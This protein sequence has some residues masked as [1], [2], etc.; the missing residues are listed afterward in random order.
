M[1]IKELEMEKKTKWVYGDDKNHYY[2][3]NLKTQIWN[4]IL[5]NEI[6]ASFQI[7]T[8]NLNKIILKNLNEAVYVE[9]GDKQA[10]VA[11]EPID[12]LD[13]DDK[14]DGFW[15]IITYGKRKDIMLVK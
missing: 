5:N 2:E 10:M 6:I 15:D 8:Y 1:R 7:Q 4:E 13:S 3:K 14:N 11:F 12:N 9:L